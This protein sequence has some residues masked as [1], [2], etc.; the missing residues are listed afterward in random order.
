MLEVVVAA[1]PELNLTVLHENH[2]LEAA[3]KAFR[4]SKLVININQGDLN[5]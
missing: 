2:L 3:R 1:T 4:P 5:N